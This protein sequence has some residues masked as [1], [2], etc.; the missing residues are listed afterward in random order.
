MKDSLKIIKHTAEEI[1]LILTEI[2][3]LANGNKTSHTVLENCIEVMELLMLDIGNKI[4]N[5]VKE[6]NVGVIIQNMKGV[7]IKE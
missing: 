2:N 3:I 4:C 1:P 5:M 7:I 6:L